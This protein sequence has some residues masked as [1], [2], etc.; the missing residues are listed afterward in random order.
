[1]GR[2]GLSRTF[3]SPGLKLVEWPE[4]AGDT[5]PAVDASLCI[6]ADEEWALP[7]GEARDEGQSNARRVRLNAHTATGQRLVSSLTA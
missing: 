6:E 4:R 2:C 3:A 5:L 1:M 7:L